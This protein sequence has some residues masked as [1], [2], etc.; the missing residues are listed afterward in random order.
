MWVYWYPPI[1]NLLQ[2]HDID[3]SNSSACSKQPGVRNRTSLH[4]MGQPS[5]TYWVDVETCWNMLK[6]VETCWNCES[7]PLSVPVCRTWRT[8]PRKKKTLCRL[9]R[10]NFPALPKIRETAFSQ[11]HFHMGTCTS[12]DGDIDQAIGIFMNMSRDEPRGP[13]LGTSSNPSTEEKQ[14]GA[15]TWSELETPKEIQDISVTC[16]KPEIHRISYWAKGLFK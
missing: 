7:Q 9:C 13:I 4:S 15:G 6:H 5:N 14:P 2:G 8:W 1:S 3:P 16:P 10:S 11:V 12:Y